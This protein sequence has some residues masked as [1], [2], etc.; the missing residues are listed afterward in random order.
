[1]RDLSLVK[2]TWSHQFILQHACINPQTVRCDAHTESSLSPNTHINSPQSSN[3]LPPARPTH[4]NQYGRPQ[5]HLHLPELLLE[6]RHALGHHL[7][8]HPA[9]PLRGLHPLHH[10]HDPRR[11]G[12]HLARTDEP[13]HIV[14]NPSPPSFPTVLPSPAGTIYEPRSKE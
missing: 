4:S 14:C 1:M 6:G 11:H 9:S 3:K 5:R 2:N 10:Q 13:P 7:A 12:L 8:L